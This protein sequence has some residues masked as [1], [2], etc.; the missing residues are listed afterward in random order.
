MN[1]TVHFRYEDTLIL[2]KFDT[3]KQAADFSQTLLDSLIGGTK[4]I[5]ITIYLTNEDPRTP[6]IASEDHE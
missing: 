6:T 4:D 3:I 5:G 1:C 2:F